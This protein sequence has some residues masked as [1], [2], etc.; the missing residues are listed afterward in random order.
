MV[1]KLVI[2]DKYL[3]EFQS[4][5]LVRVT[6]TGPFLRSGTPSCTGCQYGLIMMIF[7]PEWFT[8]AVSQSLPS[9]DRLIGLILVYLGNYLVQGLNCMVL[10]HPG[11]I[12]PFLETGAAYGANSVPSW[13]SRI[14]R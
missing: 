7:H 6:L 13:C 5:I 3:K 8:F 14:L 10:Q 9:T 1:V 11:S 12:W 4:F 2:E